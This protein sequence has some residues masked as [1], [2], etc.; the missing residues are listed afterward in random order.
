MAQL[1]RYQKGK[2]AAT[3]LDSCD[4]LA[5]NVT[6]FFFAYELFEAKL[7]S[8][9]LFSSAEEILRQLNIDSV[10]QVINNDSMKSYNEKE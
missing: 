3:V 8:F 7:K 10:A 9:G 5:K 4:I 1:R 6:F 2:I